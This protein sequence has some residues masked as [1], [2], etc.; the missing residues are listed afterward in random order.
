MSSYETDILGWSERQA[1]LLRRLANGE[2]VNDEVD[3]PNVIEEVESVGRSELAAVESLLTQA[4]SH[5][6]KLQAWP[7]APAARG[8]AKE[9]RVFRR[10]ARR[11]FTEAMRHRIDFSVL[12]AD[13]L[14]LLPDEIDGV[15]P[16]PVPVACPFT[17][18][19][20]LGGE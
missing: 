1:A 2:R 19:E 17:L 5:L 18:D 15:A 9:A 16:Q 11:K 12:Y 7:H 14:D 3:W 20:V 4:L 8:W 10:Q 6:L 13:A